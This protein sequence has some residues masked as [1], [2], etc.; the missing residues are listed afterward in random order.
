MF[1]LRD[2]SRRLVCRTV[3]LIGGIAP[4]LFVF[5]W[6]GW[7]NSSA[8]RE[9]VRT[10]LESWLDLSV[11]VNGIS[12]P[13][14]DCELMSELELVD[15]E[16][17]EA[18]LQARLVEI[19]KSKGRSITLSQP[20]V[21]AAGFRKL[22]S[23]ASRAND[24][25]SIAAGDLT[26][27]WPAGK[28]TLT[29]CSIEISSD[30]SGRTL[31]GAFALA[32]HESDLVRVKWHSA[33][34]SGGDSMELDTGGVALPCSL[35]AAVMGCESRLGR[36]ATFRG[37]ATTVHASAGWHMEIAGEFEG[38]DLNS[39][40][41]E[42]FPHQLSGRATLT[43]EKAVIRNG[44]LEELVGKVR[45]GPGI[46]SRSLLTA[47]TETLGLRGAGFAVAEVLRYEEL[48]AGFNLD[49]KGIRIRGQCGG[50]VPGGVIRSR[51]GT[52]LAEVVGAAAPVTALVRMLVPD[53]R[54]QVPATRQT[55]W[56]LQLLPLTDV[57]PRDAGALPQA[58]LRGGAELH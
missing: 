3:F 35:V 22:L 44:R 17:G 20:E 26:L 42:Q 57:Q 1:P 37:R 55:D 7:A 8:H 43:I 47:A 46:V 9:T 27:R 49:P 6:C 2:R 54:V 53:S 51:E 29:Q 34:Q 52:L 50:N 21:S 15:P 18:V 5:A 19:S 11:R 56:L 31:A 58:R 45:A 36:D 41:S 30:A 10:A 12:Y 32:G 4:M 25:V 40:I 33:R 48:A 14:P 23:V 39:I 16:T 38:L 13:R 28:Q 24:D